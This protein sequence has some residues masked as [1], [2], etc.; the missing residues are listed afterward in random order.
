VAGGEAPASAPTLPA[1]QK[2][3]TALTAEE[4]GTALSE[5]PAFKQPGPLKGRIVAVT[6]DG[7][8][9]PRTDEGT[10]LIDP[11]GRVL[12]NFTKPAPKAWVLRDGVIEE[13][14]PA[15]NT[16]YVKDLTGAPKARKLV[17]SAFTGDVKSLRELFDVYAFKT[18]APV[19]Y[20]FVLLPNAAHPN[21]AYARIEATLPADA[22]FFSKI[23]YVQ[24]EGDPVTETFLDVQRAE[25]PDAGAFV[26]KLPAGVKKQADTVQDG[27]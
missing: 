7:M 9:G 13:Y 12:R 10:L 11:P 24:R 19:A 22:L 8:L 2:G 20:R 17:E 16:L 1:A 26:L 15:L 6:D 25:K 4:L 27:K 21:L 3:E 14:A 18:A 23:L 5:L